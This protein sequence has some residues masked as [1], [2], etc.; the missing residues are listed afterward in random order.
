MSTQLK[1]PLSTHWPYQDL[2]IQNFSHWRV[3]RLVNCIL[4]TLG[5]KKKMNESNDYPH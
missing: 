4:E 2:P 1:A 5:K 3:F